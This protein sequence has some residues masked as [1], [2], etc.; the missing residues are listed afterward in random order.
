M[1]LY[2]TRITFDM[3]VFAKTPEEAAEVAVANVTEEADHTHLPSR[4]IVAA[5]MIPVPNW[6]AL[7]RGWATAMPYG[8]D[9]D[10]RT[11]GDILREQRGN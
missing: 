11:C 5:D 9:I 8:A 7:P 1:T 3:V 6:R 10:S 4:R 2:K